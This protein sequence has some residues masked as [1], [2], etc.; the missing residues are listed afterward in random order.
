MQAGRAWNW[1]PVWCPC[2]HAARQYLSRHHFDQVSSLLEELGWNDLYVTGCKMCSKS[3]ILAGGYP[4]LTQS[5]ASYLGALECII[6]ELDVMLSGQNGHYNTSV[7][8]FA[9]EES[10]N[11]HTQLCH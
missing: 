3:E 8:L 10:Y 9:C 4:A 7:V 11:I 2:S 1:I 5:S 6:G